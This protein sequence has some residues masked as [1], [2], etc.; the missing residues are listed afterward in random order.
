MANIN[1]N[2]ENMLMIVSTFIHDKKE[3]KENNED[4]KKDNYCSNIRDYDDECNIAIANDNDNRI[5]H[6]TNYNNIK[7]HISGRMWHTFI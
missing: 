7:S 3:G 6:R 5:I 2:N 4:N 1:D